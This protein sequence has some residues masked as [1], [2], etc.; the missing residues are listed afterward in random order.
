[1]PNLVT[2]A[3]TILAYVWDSQKLET[4]A[5]N[6]NTI[7]LWGRRVTNPRETKP[8]HLCYRT[9]FSRP[10]SNRMSVEP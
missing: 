3:Y 8:P 2:L 6:N 9:E 4:L 10:K 7:T 5:P 1:M